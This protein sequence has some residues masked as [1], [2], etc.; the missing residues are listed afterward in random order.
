MALRVRLRDPGGH[1]GPGELREHLD[2]LPRSGFVQQRAR[3]LGRYS[4]QKYYPLAGRRGT[5]RSSP[6]Q[7][8]P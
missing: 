5:K 8:R 3:A 4:G 1:I 2:K 6:P 7:F